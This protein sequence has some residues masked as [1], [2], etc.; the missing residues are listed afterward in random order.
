[1]SR[2]AYFKSTAMVDSDQN[3]EIANIK[4]RL[5]T[6]ETSKANVSDL[7]LGLSAKA[8][9]A[10]VNFAL[11][12]K[13]STIYVDGQ[14]ATKAATSYVDEQLSTK[15]TSAEHQVLVNEVAARKAAENAWITAVKD[16]IYIE[17]TPGS[18][19]E[20]DYSGLGLSS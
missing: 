3:A 14:L 5:S 17:S 9:T 11:D 8:D 20:F 7:N 13:A 15:A 1:M 18:G 2:V 10:V 12:Q 4:V 19:A 16:A 6:V